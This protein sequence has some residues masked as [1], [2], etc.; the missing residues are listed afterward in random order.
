MIVHGINELFWAAFDSFL[1]AAGNVKPFRHGGNDG[2][3]WGWSGVFAI[4]SFHVL[5]RM[6]GVHDLANNIF[7]FTI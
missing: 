2:Q 4:K 3:G 5:L 1:P 7:I 6:G